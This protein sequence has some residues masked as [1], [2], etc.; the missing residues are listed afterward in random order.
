MNITHGFHA[1]MN[2][3]PGRGGELVELLLHCSVYAGFPAM[4]TGA[5][6]LADILEERG[7]LTLEDDQPS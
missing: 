6:I 1:I 5:H 4:V 7:E 3:H 2:A